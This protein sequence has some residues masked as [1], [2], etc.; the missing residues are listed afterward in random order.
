MVKFTAVWD[1][2]VQCG[3]VYANVGLGEGFGGPNQE[4]R[5]GFVE[6][7]RLILPNTWPI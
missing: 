4:Q 1:S 7:S 6:V 5:E 3:L 2:L